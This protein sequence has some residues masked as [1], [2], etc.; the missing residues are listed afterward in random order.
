MHSEEL[1]SAWWMKVI[2]SIVKWRSPPEGPL[3]S[4]WFF[5]VVCNVQL[6]CSTVPFARIIVRFVSI[7]GCLFVAPSGSFVLQSL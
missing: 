2:V 6:V 5:E 3:D 7:S 4:V 1:A